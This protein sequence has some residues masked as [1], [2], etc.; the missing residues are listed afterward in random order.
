VKK[1]TFRLDQVLRVR[2]VQEELA[3]A[4]LQAANREVA[5]AEELLVARF[6]HY[7]EIPA[8]ESAVTTESFVASRSMAD[9]IAG[10]VIA[11]GALHQAAR[12]QA[13]DRR[14]AWSAAAMRVTALERLDDRR[15]TEHTLEAGREEDRQ[16]D[17][18]VVS[19]F[20]AGGAA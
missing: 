6:E 1:Y 5:R 14:T 16:A 8:V 13:G 11:A 7:Q 4:E 12:D 17:E 18:G 9:V 3:R 10:G 19:R 20:R 15:R 2:R